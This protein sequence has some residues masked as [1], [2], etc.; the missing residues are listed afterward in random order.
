MGWEKKK[1]EDMLAGKKL[2]PKIIYQALLIREQV[3]FVLWNHSLSRL[4]CP[5]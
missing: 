2:S 4:L 1:K 3:D 5:V